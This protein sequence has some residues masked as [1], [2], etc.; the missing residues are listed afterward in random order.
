MTTP[1]LVQLILIIITGFGTFLLYF[2]K[3]SD[4]QG[5]RRCLQ[6]L[7]LSILLSL[8]GLLV[9]WIGVH[10]L[11]EII[12]FRPK[13]FYI[14]TELYSAGIGIFLGTLL[15]CLARWIR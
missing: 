5:R 14:G 8:V 3:P 6:L 10:D 4:F 1:G 15:V 2:E 13:D 12:F 9:I 11:R 7:G